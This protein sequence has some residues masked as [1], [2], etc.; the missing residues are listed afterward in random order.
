MD[1]SRDYSNKDIRIKESFF[2]LYINP[3]G[4]KSILSKFSISGI[5]NEIREKKKFSM[6]LVTQLAGEPSKRISSDKVV[7]KEEIERK[8]TVK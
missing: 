6:K 7:Y 5:Y 8:Q 3:N 1:F 4:Q 2:T